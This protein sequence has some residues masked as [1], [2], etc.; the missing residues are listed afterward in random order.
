M[1]YREGY[2]FGQRFKQTGDLL[3]EIIEKTDFIDAFASKITRVKDPTRQMD[4]LNNRFLG[5]EGFQVHVIKTIL[6]VARLDKAFH[7]LRDFFAELL[8]CFNFD[9]TLFNL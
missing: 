2:L 7:D 6:G 9:S 3:S 8:R 5:R 1:P 4:D